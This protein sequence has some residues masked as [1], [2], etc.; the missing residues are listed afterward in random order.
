MAT[1]K[2]LVATIAN[3]EGIGAERV[4]AIPQRALR[5][6]DLVAK[7]VAEAPRQPK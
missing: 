1:L 4:R 5:E 2:S 6:A 3:V 7:L